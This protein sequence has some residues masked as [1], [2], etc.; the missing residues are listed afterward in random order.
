MK[1]Y[2]GAENIISPL[3]CTAQEN[4]EAAFA[5]KSG[6]KEI[7]EAGFSKTNFFLSK[8][9]KPQS[10]KQLIRE[11]LKGIDHNLIASP[12]TKVILCS[13]KGNVEDNLQESLNSVLEDFIATYNVVN[14]PL[15][16]S[17]ACISSVLGVVKAADLIRA[18]LY[19]NVLVVGVDL[20]SDF[21]V[22]GFE[23]LYALADG[24]CK[25]YD[26]DRKGI[27][28]GEACASV[29]LSK[30]KEIFA[31]APC[32]YISGSA[33][34]DANHISGPSRTG[35]GLFRSVT[36]TMTAGNITS[37]E[38]DYISAHG[39]ATVYNDNM[40][41]IAFSRLKLSSVPMN[42]FKGYFGHTLGAAGT[43]EIALTLQSI[44]KQSLI[45][46]LGYS[47]QG[48]DFPLNVITKSQKGTVNT[49]LKTSSGFG[50]VNASL[51]IKKG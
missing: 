5:G 11:C 43:L 44:R 42:S 41:S 13:T 6:I 7:A 12:K 30:H 32:E 28:L 4:F 18:N 26:K 23:A 27:N 31:E 47:E 49:V 9:E 3:G 33:S 38:I 1:V 24:L 39:T 36:K 46:S 10:I 40:E 8:F 48:T 22:Y 50:G 2:I 15:F 16:I 51:I 34:N 17:N 20:V 37:E 14:Q 45:K 35:E 29:L 25:P 19:D 21:I